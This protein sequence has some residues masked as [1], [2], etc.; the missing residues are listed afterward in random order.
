LNLTSGVEADCKAL[1][2]VGEACE[3]TPFA[4]GCI[5]FTGA[6]LDGYKLAYC[7]VAATAWEDG[8]DD[9][10]G[11]SAVNRAR[12]LACTLE[13]EVPTN[14]GSRCNDDISVINLCK[15]DPLASNFPGCA[16]LAKF[17][18]YVT[19]YCTGENTWQDACDMRAEAEARDNDVFRARLGACLVADTAEPT[20]CPPLI[21][22][23]CGDTDN[24][25]NAFEDICGT[26]KYNANR[27]AQLQK[28]CAE[29]GLGAMNSGT[30]CTDKSRAKVY[31]TTIDPYAG[32]GCDELAG[33]Q[34]VI[35]FRMMHCMDNAGL[36]ECSVAVADVC[37]DNPFDARCVDDASVTTYADARKARADACV[38]DSP[39]V[40]CTRVNACN[41]RPFSATPAHIPA[42]GTATT[43]SS[44]PAFV[45][46]RAAL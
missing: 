36:P 6:V 5:I 19:D 14:A 32:I 24:S 44:D 30:F 4:D 28:A 12:T 46:I 1:S 43:C 38:L 7:S 13:A 34:A 2:S 37:A 31:C 27:G 15:D 10:V 17:E 42:T 45:A 41:A 9:L 23:H 11:T 26:S 35:D 33:E 16:F 20:D 25:A 8:C 39:S 40:D 21:T 29:G 22:A 18:E 3:A